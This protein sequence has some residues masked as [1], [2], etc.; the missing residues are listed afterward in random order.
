MSTLQPVVSACF[1]YSPDG[2]IEERATVVISPQSIKTIGN[3][4]RVLWACSRGVSCKTPSCTFSGG[5]IDF[6]RRPR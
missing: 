5:R 6:N 4:A 1:N 2:N 3:E